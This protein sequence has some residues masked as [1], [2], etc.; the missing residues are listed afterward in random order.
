MILHW[1]KGSRFHGRLTLELVSL[2]HIEREPDATSKGAKTELQS[3]NAEGM[4]WK[5]NIKQ[6]FCAST[7]FVKR[8]V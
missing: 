2:P 8:K 4:E 1:E 7:G 6:S 5:E 3:S